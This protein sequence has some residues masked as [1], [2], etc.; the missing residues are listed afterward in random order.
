MADSITNLAQILYQIEPDPVTSNNVSAAVLNG[1]ANADVGV[2]I[3]VDKP[4]PLVGENVTFTV[5]VA[6]RG[7]SPAT[8][9][10]VADVLSAGLTLVSATPSQGTW[11]APNWTVGTLSEIAAPVTLTVVAT[12]TASGA[13]VNGA[14]ITQQTEGDSNPVNNRA[15]RHA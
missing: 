2:N 1:Q 3:T 10:V 6:N 8:G 5:T 13:M 7:P 14:I 11:V 9:L 15:E 4:A 12:V